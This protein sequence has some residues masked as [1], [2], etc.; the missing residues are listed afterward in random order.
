M[1]F[2][3]DYYTCDSEHSEC[4]SKK[5]C[6]VKDAALLNEQFL[7]LR[8]QGSLIFCLS[9]FD[10]RAWCQNERSEASV[11]TAQTDERLPKNVLF[12]LARVNWRAAGSRAS[13]RAF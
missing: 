3:A 5:S 12:S 13:V 4:V 8:L 10:L 11:K 7:L 6:S 9:W 2:Q 1:L